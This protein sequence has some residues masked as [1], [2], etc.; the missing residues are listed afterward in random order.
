MAGLRSKGIPES[1]NTPCEMYVV[2][3]DG[4]LHLLIL[5]SIDVFYLK[6][7]SDYLC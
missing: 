4:L 5:K 3:T 6:G 2:K 7:T 1:R